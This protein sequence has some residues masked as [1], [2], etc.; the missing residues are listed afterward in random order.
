VKSMKADEDEAKSRSRSS[1]WTKECEMM[2][3]LNHPNIIRAFE[4]PAD[5]RQIADSHFSLLAMEYCPDGDLRKVP[6]SIG[7]IENCLHLFHN[8]ISTIT[9]FVVR[10]S[11]CRK[12]CHYVHIF[13]KIVWHGIFFAVTL[14]TLCCSFCSQFFYAVVL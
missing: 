3:I 8:I 2:L 11:D 7:C 6:S 5:I 4:V 14:N 10:I 13:A 1:N 9:T 12:Y